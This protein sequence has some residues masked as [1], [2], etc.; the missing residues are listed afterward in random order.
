MKSITDEE[1]GLKLDSQTLVPA[2]VSD[3]TRGRKLEPQLR[4]V[5][6][7]K[8]KALFIVLLFTAGRLFKEEPV[9]T[10]QGEGFETLTENTE[11]RS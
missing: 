5:K 1:E 10:E 6:S 2:P 7:E 3:N 4:Y 11:L 9:T 8:H